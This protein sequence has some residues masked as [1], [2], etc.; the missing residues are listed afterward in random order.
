MEFG[1]GFGLA[2][3]NPVSGSFH[4]VACFGEAG[5]GLVKVGLELG[6]TLTLKGTVCI[7]LVG[8]VK[9]AR[10]WLR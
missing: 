4:F 9:Q 6:L 10:A 8:F 7:S 2:N 5:Q 3:P 1:L